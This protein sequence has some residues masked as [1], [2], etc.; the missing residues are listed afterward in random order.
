YPDALA[1]LDQAAKLNPNNISILSNRGNVLLDLDD[2]VRGEAVFTRLVRANPRNAEFVRQLGRAL[3]KQGKT[4]AAMSRARQAIAL[5]KT[6]TD[7]WLDMVGWLNEEG[8]QAEAEALLDK[9]TEANPD[10]PKLL[11]ARAIVMRRTQQIR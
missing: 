10:N 9:A 1:A 3:Y 8:K 7:A 5:Q 4:A 11:E 2:G 6:L